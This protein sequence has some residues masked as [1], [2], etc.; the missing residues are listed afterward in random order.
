MA[1]PNIEHYAAATKSAWASYVAEHGYSLTV[2]DD[3]V[4]RDLHINWSKIEH[5]RQHLLKSDCDWMVIT[6]ADSLVHDRQR[7][8]ESLLSVCDELAMV[9][10]ADVARRWRLD[11]PLN[12]KGVTQARRWVLPNAGFFAVRNSEDGRTFMN[13]WM[14]LATGRLSYLA[15]QVPRDQLVLW[16]G[17]LPKWDDKIKILGAEVVRV[18]SDRHWRH[19]LH[20]ETGIF[21]RHDKRLK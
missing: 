11:F 15:D 14:Q 13:E 2:Y 9:F 3:H 18:L 12:P 16:R 4:R 7:R 17:L 8:L 10:S 5:A 19:L 20:Y 21:I 6:D 1:T